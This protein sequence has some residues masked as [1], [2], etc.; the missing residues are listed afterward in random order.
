MHMIMLLA[1]EV[2]DFMASKIY[3]THAYNANSKFNGDHKLHVCGG[4]GG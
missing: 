3:C 1:R 2:C 4:G